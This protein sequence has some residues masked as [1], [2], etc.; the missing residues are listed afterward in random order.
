MNNEMLEIEV[1]EKTYKLGY[2]TRK[3][4]KIA[5]NNGLRLLQLE[6]KPI[7]VTEKLF[8]TGLLAKHPSTTEAEA[9][10]L[11]NQYIEEGG[12]VREINEFLTKQYL[13]FQ[14]S[15]DGKK[16]KKAKIIKI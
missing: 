12:E 4:A 16:K 15:P 6:E 3:D 5:E 8:F 13:A 14:Q 11:L 1:G 2:P 7:G 9:E 10:K